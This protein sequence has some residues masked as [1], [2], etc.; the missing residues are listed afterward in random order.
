MKLIGVIIL[1]FRGIIT[2]GS[3]FLGVI[4][5]ELKGIIFPN[6]GIIHSD[7]KVVIRPGLAAVKHFGVIVCGYM[8]TIYCGCFGWISTD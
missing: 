1:M 6:F 4:Y 8:G 2:T 5:G 7:L 3:D